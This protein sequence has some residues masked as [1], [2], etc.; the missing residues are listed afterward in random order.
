[1]LD[2]TCKSLHDLGAQ[3]PIE[4]PHPLSFTVETCLEVERE[5]RDCD[6]NG[7]GPHQEF[8][9]ERSM[10]IE[11]A[12]QRSLAAIHSN[13]GDIDAGD[14]DAGNTDTDDWNILF[15]LA[16]SLDPFALPTT[17]TP[18]PNPAQDSQIEP[19]SIRTS[20]KPSSLDGYP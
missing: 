9:K 13:S 15:D 5:L 12:N 11:S 20:S 10:H 6:W 3:I 7:I 14:F 19:D 16:E 8:L 17:L 2:Q 1:M 4:Y 18:P